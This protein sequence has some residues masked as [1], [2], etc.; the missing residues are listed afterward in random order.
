[1]MAN[2]LKPLKRYSQ[3]FL[4]TIHFQQKIVEALNCQD[5]DVVIEIGA[6]TGNLTRLLVASPARKVILFEIDP[7]CIKILKKNYG[8]RALII[9]SS[10]LDFNFS[11]FD[12]GPGFKIKVVGNIPYHLTSA[13][14]FKLLDSKRYIFQ[15]VLM[16]QQE[17]ADRILAQP[18]NKEYG[19]L[20]L[21][22][23]C[24][25][26]VQRLFNVDRNNF[27]PI[28]NVD[29]TVI[30]LLIKTGASGILDLDLFS[31]LVRTTFQTRR[32]MLR[33]SLMRLL[34]YEYIKSIKSV[35]LLNR[36]EQLSFEDF[37]NLTNEISKLNNNL[38]HKK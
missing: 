15:A 28:P 1:M 6:G 22:V 18:N 20:T 30:N 13:I 36:P 35:S 26:H 32:K 31:K 25:A 12:Y 16:L 27:F 9:E 34:K 3:N 29:S 17:V 24:Q 33:N 23:A 19:V 5:N 4:K 7:R 38:L 21:M 37:K 2:H 11:K 14:I 10:I 8:Q